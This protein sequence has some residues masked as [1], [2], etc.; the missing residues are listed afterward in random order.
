MALL[1]LLLLVIVGVVRLLAIVLL[2]WLRCILRPLLRIWLPILH[3][4]GE[5]STRSSIHIAH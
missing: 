1:R 5:T 3:V 2:R 4:I